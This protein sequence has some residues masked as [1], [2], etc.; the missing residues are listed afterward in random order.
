MTNYTG[1]LTRT[2]AELRHPGDDE[3][4]CFTPSAAQPNTPIKL[5][6]IRPNA[7]WSGEVS[8]DRT[9]WFLRCDYGFKLSGTAVFKNA[10]YELTCTEV[11]VPPVLRLPGEEGM[12]A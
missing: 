5:T 3:P 6:G 8:A 7:H 1:R 4:L 10:A 2:H 11:Y 9:T 12:A